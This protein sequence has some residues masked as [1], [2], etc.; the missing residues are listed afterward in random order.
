[1][2][3]SLNKHLYANPLGNHFIHRESLFSNSYFTRDSEI[4]FPP[5]YLELW[6][7]LRDVTARSV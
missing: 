6:L 5:P 2:L 1:M 3:P 4:L 7:P